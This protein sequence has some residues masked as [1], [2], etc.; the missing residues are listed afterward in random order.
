M[1]LRRKLALF[2][3]SLA[4]L[5]GLV[6]AEDYLV[7]S[8]YAS[9]KSKR[10]LDSAGNYNISIIH[11]N[12]IHA[13][14]DQFRATAGTDC[15][16]RYE[17]AGGY[18]RIK[19]KVD[20]LRKGAKDSLLFSIGDEFQGTLFYSYYGG[21]KIAETMNV[22]GYDAMTLGNHEFDGGDDKLAAFLANLTF[23]VVSANIVT[24]HTG[25]S[26]I[27][28]PYHIF[29]QHSLAV[30]GVTTPV[31]K[32]TSSA[33]PGTN[34]LDPIE[35]I[36]ATVDAIKTKEK[37]TKIV[38]ITHLGY[39]QDIE[40]ASKTRGIHLIMGGHSHTL[41]GSMPG[42]AGPYPTI[43]KNLDG[44]DVFV[45]TAYRWGEYIGYLDIAFDP[46]GRIA[47]YT[48][49]PIRLTNTTAQDPIMQAKVD[50][51]R[52][53]FDAFAKEIVGSTTGLLDQSGCQSGEC[54]FG[55]L[56][57]DVMYDYRIKSG[58]NVDGAFTN[59]GGI[60]ASISAGNITRG[61]ILTAFPFGN[62]IV[63]LSFTGKEL[64]DMF[65]GIVSKVNSAGSAVT[66]FVQ[67]SQSISITYDPSK[68]VGSRLVSL[69][70]SDPLQAVDLTKTYTLAT[71]DFLATGGDYFLTTPKTDFIVL[72]KLD[73]VLTAYVQE[74]S[75]I[76][77][78]ITGRITKL[79]SK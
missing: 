58:G 57:S 73:E 5:S 40:L 56:I 14:L 42:A 26:S 75:P 64:W 77:P 52:A 13:H 46:A 9:A 25:I 43:Q 48:G 53:P 34:F 4:V 8:R 36:Q 55:N 12:D 20:Q 17:C 33:G 2:S 61:D 47:A 6:L 62:A 39:E 70:V 44:E 3:A 22:L 18:S 59:A 30:I 54:T 66:S 60:R 76:T 35:V 16:P 24:N 11:T 28:K 10:Y 63:D 15:D 7:S 50:A 68:P 51:W 72:D 38:A 49:G 74:H 45:V 1:V 27:L 29:P 79:S 71:I 78:A 21:E 37:I 23:P 31:T 19:T 32:G 41:V 69:K 67:V 65:E